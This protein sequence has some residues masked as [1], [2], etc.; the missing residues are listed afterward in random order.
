MELST[1]MHKSIALPL[2][3]ANLSLKNMST[4]NSSITSHYFVIR[5][6]GKKT[7]FDPNKITVAITKAFLAVEG[8]S[9]NAS[10]RIHQKVQSISEQVY[11]ALIRRLPESG[12]LYIE[13]IQDQVELALMR[14]GEQKVARAYV[15]YRTERAQ[16]RAHNEKEQKQT[17]KKEVITSITIQDMND[18][19]VTIYHSDLQNYMTH[20]VEELS[21]ADPLRI[22]KEILKN[23][24]DGMKQ[25]ELFEIMIL[26]ARSLIVQDPAYSQVSAR[27]LLN[28]LT[29]EARYFIIQSPLNWNAITERS[30]A[31]VFASIRHCRLVMFNCW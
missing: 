24:F 16:K 28:K 14:S 20:I 2:I 21:D 7:P 15:L 4:K 22:F 5:R 26:S 1:F 10:E 3:K 19:T 12:I 30:R 9:A 17:E 18:E 23:C 8:D 25:S 13:E 31:L 29:H 27:L 11:H 6:N